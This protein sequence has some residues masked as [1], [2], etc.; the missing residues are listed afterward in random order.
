MI[1]TKKS[2]TQLKKL[3]KRKL[4]KNEMINFIYKFHKAIK[5]MHINHFRGF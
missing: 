3:R 4:K 1:E 5:D 2:R